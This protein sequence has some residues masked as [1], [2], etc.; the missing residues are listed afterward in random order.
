MAV[1][2][3]ATGITTQGLKW[4]LEAATLEPWQARGLSNVFTWPI[5]TISVESG[6]LLAIL[7]G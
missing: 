5:A 1:G 2:G 4:D 7:P 3:M 6:T